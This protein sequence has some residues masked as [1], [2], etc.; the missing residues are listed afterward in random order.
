ME[1]LSNNWGS[2]SLLLLGVLISDAV[3]LSRLKANSVVQLLGQAFKTLALLKTKKK[4][5]LP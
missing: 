4:G 1:F 2:T 3:G 5:R